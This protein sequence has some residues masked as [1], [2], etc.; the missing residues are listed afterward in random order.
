MTRTT[1][2]F[3]ASELSAVLILCRLARFFCC[4]TPY[5]TQYAAHM[6]LTGILQ[7]ILLIPVFL[8]K[9]PYAVPKLTMRILEGFSLV[10]AADTAADC[11]RLLTAAD[12]PSPVLTMLLLFAAVFY[13][14]S[15]PRPAIFRASVFLLAAA[16]L[17]FALLPLGGL[18]S[19][20]ILSLWTSPPAPQGLLS[21]WTESAELALIPMFA[22]AQ[23]AA[24]KKAAASWIGARCI[25]LPAIVLFGTMQC[26]RLR[27]FHGN[28]F[29]LLLARVPLSDALRTDGLWLML[30]VACALLACGFFLQSFCGC[31][32][33]APIRRRT[34]GVSLLFALTILF[35]IY[36]V[37]G[38][39]LAC[40]AIALTILQ[41][42]RPK[43]A[44]A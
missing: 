3:S 34:I 23:P 30:A 19:A 17:A 24:S 37:N 11:Y 5:S 22:A 13:A 40:A 15:L 4:E 44:S 10:L 32:L 35:I 41:W 25:A 33:R 1:P 28:P 43:E 42:Y 9:T 7:A 14:V 16:I 2:E 6:L 27:T 29:L 31:R 38:G 21:E 39:I 20:R 36:N 26:G 12:A 18:S 8:R